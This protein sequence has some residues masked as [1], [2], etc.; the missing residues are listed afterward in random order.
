MGARLARLLRGRDGYTLVELLAVMVIFVTVVGT[1]TT[2]FTAGA[3]AELDLNRRFEAQQ[4]A[5]LALDKLRR[6]LHCSDGVTQLDGSPLSTAPVAAIRVSL[7]A[8]CPSAG[9]VDTTVTYVMVSAGA[10]RWRLERTQNTTTVPIADFI[11]ND[12]VFVYYAESA[13]ARARLHVDFPVN[14]NPIEGW[15]EWRLV[16]DIVLRNT[17]REDPSA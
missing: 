5:R 11:T 14:V 13:D 17:L 16:D 15:K 12:D 7:L 3:K 4:N 8:H 9:G 6:E 1:L 10:D 2:L